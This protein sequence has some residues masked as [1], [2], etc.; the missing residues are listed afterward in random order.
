MAQTTNVYGRR[1]ANATIH[2][3]LRFELFSS[4]ETE[5]CPPSIHHPTA[6]ANTSLSRPLIGNTYHKPSRLENRI[7]LTGSVD[8]A[9]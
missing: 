6:D 7:S 3:G 8:L 5:P 1:K 4:C 9:N 2:I